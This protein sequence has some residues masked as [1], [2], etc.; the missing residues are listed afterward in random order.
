[1]NLLSQEYQSVHL[2]TVNKSTQNIPACIM[3]TDTLFSVFLYNMQLP[4]EAVQLNS[5][6]PCLQGGFF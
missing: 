2:H 4:K 6:Q 1:M 5:S 3:H